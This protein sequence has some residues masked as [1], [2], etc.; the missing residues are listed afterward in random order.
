[1]GKRLK[2]HNKIHSLKFDK[3]VTQI[4]IFMAL[5]KYL[6]KI[7]FKTNF[8]IPIYSSINI[9]VFFYGA[10][11]IWSQVQKEAA[12]ACACVH[13]RD[14]TCRPARA[15]ASCLVTTPAPGQYLMSRHW[16]HLARACRIASRRLL[17]SARRLAGR[18]KHGRWDYGWKGTKFFPYSH[19]TFS[20]F[21]RPFTYLRDLVFIFAEIENSV[22]RSFSS[23]PV[24]IR[25]RP[26]FIP[27]SIY[28]QYVQ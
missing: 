1:V 7:C 6:I 11:G 17:S 9:S 4:L 13:C 3:H 28:A 21:F 22:F 5:N 8:M 10:T 12:R 19:V 18:V 26:V 27:F 16:I 24:L 23:N 14:D 15:C 20:I 25:N 2:T